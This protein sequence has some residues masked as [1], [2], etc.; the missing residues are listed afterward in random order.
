MTA[1]SCMVVSPYD[2]FRPMPSA[3]PQHMAGKLR[4]APSSSYARKAEIHKARRQSL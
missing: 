1:L 4:Q 2:S 3:L